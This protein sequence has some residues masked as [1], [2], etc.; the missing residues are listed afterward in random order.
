M[1]YFALRLAMLRPIS[2]CHQCVFGLR[3]CLNV[4][5]NGFLRRFYPRLCWWLVRVFISACWP[6]GGFSRNLGPTLVVFGM[7]FGHVFE[8]AIFE[9]CWIF[10]FCLFCKKLALENPYFF[11]SRP[12]IGEC[13][14]HGAFEEHSMSVTLVCLQ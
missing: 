3:R 7:V 2:A 13:L 14:Y 9:H 11:D 12:T 5:F 1:C 8:N 6:L 10:S 4:S